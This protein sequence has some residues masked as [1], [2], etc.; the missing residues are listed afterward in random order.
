[1]RRKI[2]EV[3]KWRPFTDANG[4]VYDLIHLGDHEVPKLDKVNFF[5]IAK[6]L[7]LGTLL[8]KP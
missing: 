4:Q 5:N 6:N 3:A 7:R 2:D 8:P 1:M